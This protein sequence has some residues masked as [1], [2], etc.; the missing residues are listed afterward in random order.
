MEKRNKYN[1]E[2]RLR[3]VKAVLK[4][5]HSLKAVAKRHGIEESNLRLWVGF[6]QA[7]GTSGL[8]PGSNRKYDIAFKLQVLK[9]VDQEGLSLR[10]AAI[11]FKIPSESVIISWQKAFRQAGEMGLLSK[12][13][14][15]PEM[16][17]P[18]KRKPRNSS[19][20]MTREEKLLEEND[21]LRAENEL[22]KKLQALVQMS[23]KQKP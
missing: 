13:K 21:Y 9:A 8:K 11:K 1:Y 5:K 14:G 12:P 20:P 15:R 18:I 3:C 4:C 16:K 19:K 2:F 10:C 23:K 7:Y 17:K 6:Y 22:L